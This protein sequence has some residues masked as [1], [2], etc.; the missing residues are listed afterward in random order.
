MWFKERRPA[1]HKI[2]NPRGT[3][4]RGCL[5]NSIPYLFCL[6]FKQYIN[7]PVQQ[8]GNWTWLDLWNLLSIKLRDKSFHNSIGL[9][10]IYFQVS[11][12]RWLGEIF[13]TVQI[14]RKCICET[15]LPF[16]HN[17][18]LDPMQN[19]PPHSPPPYFCGE[20]TLCLSSHLSPFLKVSS[21]TSVVQTMAFKS[22]TT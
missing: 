4:C 11:L 13:N 10:R 5:S 14:T 6:L 1:L 7:T 16:L 21:L 20:E 2:S 19:I 3:V 22:K 18:I 17:L 9:V 8:E 12:S 15:F